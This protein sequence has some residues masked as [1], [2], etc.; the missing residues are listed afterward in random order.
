MDISDRDP[1][2]TRRQLVNDASSQQVSMPVVGKSARQGKVSQTGGSAK[3]SPVKRT[4]KGKRKVN[5]MF[6]TPFAL[7]DILTP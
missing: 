4:V 6:L 2:D 1:S 5:W 3:L 7:F